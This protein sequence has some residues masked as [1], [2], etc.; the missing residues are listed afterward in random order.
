MLDIFVYRKQSFQ[1]ELGILLVFLL[2]F[3]ANKW[4]ALGVFLFT[5]QHPLF[6]SEQFSFYSCS[7]A[8]L[9]LSFQQP[10]KKRAKDF[11]SRLC[12]GKAMVA[13]KKLQQRK[14]ESERPRGER[15]KIKYIDCIFERWQVAG[16]RKARRR[17]DSP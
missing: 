3:D 10:L 14:K 17:Q 6:H 4:I 13:Y 9:R 1:N 15:D 7:L 2:H 11:F 12:C 16:F 8:F 5:Y